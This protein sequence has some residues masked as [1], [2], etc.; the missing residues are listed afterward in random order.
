VVGAGAG[1]MPLEKGVSIS[2]IGQNVKL[3]RA[4]VSQSPRH[5]ERAGRKKKLGE[6]IPRHRC[7]IR[8][9]QRKLFNC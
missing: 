9:D 3:Q 6:E 1:E 4:E 5:H 7:P 8:R 2:M